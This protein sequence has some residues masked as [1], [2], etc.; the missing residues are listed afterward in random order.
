MDWLPNEEGIRWLLEHVWPKVIKKQPKARLHLAGN[1]MPKDL[2]DA[3][4]EGVTIS[5]RVRNSNS[6]MG[7][8]HV[9]VVPLFSAGGMRVKIIEGMA[10]AKC[11]ISTPIGAEGIDHTDGENIVLARTATE[12]AEAMVEALEDPERTQRIGRKARKLVEERYSDGRIVR[13]LSA[14]FKSIGKG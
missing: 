7:A 1:K 8:R 10:M 2:M 13:D 6:W 5:G 9:M 12:F 3:A 4:I 14:F 11:A